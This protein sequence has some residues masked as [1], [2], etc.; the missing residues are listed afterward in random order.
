LKPVVL[1]LISNSR[2]CEIKIAMRSTV[3]HDS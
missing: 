2:R 3:R 1:M